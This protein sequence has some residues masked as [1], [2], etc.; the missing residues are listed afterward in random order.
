V[1]L[2]ADQIKQAD[3]KPREYPLFDSDGLVLR[4]LPSG[5]KTWTVIYYERGRKRR[6]TVGRWPDVGLRAARAERD[7]IKAQAAGH[8]AVTLKQFVEGEYLP[9]VR[10]QLRGAAEAERII[11]KDILPELGRRPVASITRRECTQVLDRVRDRGASEMAVATYARLRRVLQYAV[12]RGIR[13]D[14]PAQ[15]MQVRQGP[16]RDRALRT[17]ELVAWWPALLRTAT[18]APRLALALVLATGQRPGEVLDMTAEDLDPI[19]RVWEI[20]REKAKNG[21]GHRVPLTDWAQDLIGEAQGLWPEADRIIPVSEDTVRS[22]MRAAVT[23]ARIAR[24]TPH[25]LRRTV[26]TRLGELGYS[27][28]IQDK[29]LNHK[30][31]SVGGIYDRYSYMQEKRAALEAWAAKFHEIVSSEGAA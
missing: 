8:D 31:K 29:I 4:V 17:A 10:D 28:Q 2:T 21:I 18:A 23:E 26:A 13:D 6:A 30:D 1:P 11:R 24:A 19:D 9:A 5:T 3:P 22:Y 12:E 25:D 14:N 20:P 7:R 16:A 15:A 27:R